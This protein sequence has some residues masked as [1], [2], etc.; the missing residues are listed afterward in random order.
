MK[1]RILAVLC[2]VFAAVCFLSARG[3]GLPLY[4]GALWAVMPTILAIVLIVKSLIRR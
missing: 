1:E 4:V 2:L 3:K